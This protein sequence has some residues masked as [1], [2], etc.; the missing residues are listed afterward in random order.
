MADMQPDQ[1]DQAE[2][3]KDEESG[4]QLTSSYHVLKKASLS[5][6]MLDDLKP[7][8]S[9]FVEG[10]IDN[11]EKANAFILNHR[12]RFRAAP[13]QAGELQLSLF[14]IRRIQARMDSAASTTP[15]I[16]VS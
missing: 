9:E 13:I 5:L 16:G 2:S 6:A 11:D 14:M 8:L 7:L 10:T 3:Q 12:D 4:P 1:V 15:M